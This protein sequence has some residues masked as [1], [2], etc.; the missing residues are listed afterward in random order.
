MVRRVLSGVH[1]LLQRIQI[2][3]KLGNV[4]ATSR[5]R[6]SAT[7]S[8]TSRLDFAAH[9][10]IGLAPLRLQLFSDYAIAIECYYS[11]QA[12]WLL[13]G[14]ITAFVLRSAIWGKERCVVNSG[15]SLSSA[16]V[17]LS[18]HLPL[19]VDAAATRSRSS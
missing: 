11:V 10:G 18:A 16:A 3:L 14:V 7:R 6:Q 8:V 2:F 19:G 9:C 5:D 17:R 13:R 4:G 12:K 15:S 1:L